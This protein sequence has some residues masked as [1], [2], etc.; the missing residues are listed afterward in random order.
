MSALT[1][2]AYQRYFG[3]GEWHEQDRGHD[4]FETDAETDMEGIS[5]DPLLVGIY[6]SGSLGKLK[7]AIGKSE[8]DSGLA[9][10]EPSRLGNVLLCYAENEWAT[11]V[12]S[13]E[14]WRPTS[15]GALSGARE[16]KT[17]V[18]D[19]A[20]PASKV[21][22]AFFLKHARRDAAVSGVKLATKEQPNE[23]QQ[24]F[25]SLSLEWREATKFSSSTSEIVMHEAYQRIIGL[26]PTAIPLIL[27]DLRENG[28]YWF[29][30][31]R[32][33]T[34]ENPVSKGDVGRIKKMTE[35]WLDWG[36]INGLI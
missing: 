12:E 24:L 1:Q 2:Q 27:Q 30:A 8:G 31:L 23:L 22:P 10:I 25:L 11:F 32:A 17:S 20:A 29:W 19:V 3:L 13:R 9:H 7:Q 5:A 33:L 35:A 15:Y 18:R 34:R 6:R 28:G 26:G 4:L 16:L 36:K 14:I 21:A